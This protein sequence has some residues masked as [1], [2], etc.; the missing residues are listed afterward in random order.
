M[1]DG[2]Q[3]GRPKVIVV[4]RSLEGIFY[5]RL[6]RRFAQRNDLRVIVDRRDGDRRQNR[7][8]A[9]PGSD[10]DRRTGQRRRE[11]TIWSLAELPPYQ[12]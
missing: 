9:A 8:P 1:A 11:R 7:H 6:A 12:P 5:D 4:P 3:S 10:A 2:T